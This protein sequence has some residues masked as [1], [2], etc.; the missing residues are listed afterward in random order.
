[1]ASSRLNFNMSPRFSEQNT[2]VLLARKR[3]RVAANGCSATISVRRWLDGDLLLRD[4]PN[5]STEVTEDLP[6]G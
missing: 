1:M 2:I 3:R 4:E 6:S 5:A